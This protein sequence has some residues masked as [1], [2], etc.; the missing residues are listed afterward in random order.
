MSE[1][2]RVRA[3]EGQREGD[4]ESEAGSRLWALNCQHRARREARI[5]K[6]W[7]NDLSW[8]WT[9]NQLSHP[10]VPTFKGFKVKKAP[11]LGRQSVKVSHLLEFGCLAIGTG[12]FGLKPRRQNHMEKSWHLISLKCLRCGLV[13]WMTFQLAA[14]A[15]RRIYRGAWAAQSVKHPTLAQVMNSWFVGW[16]PM[17]GSANSSECGACFGFCFS[18][19]LSV[20]L[21]LMLCLSASLSQKQT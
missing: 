1:R 16:S 13:D 4:T 9:R 7:D 2:D 12:Q 3:G 17:W 5:H 20:P 11:D 8:G 15:S 21:L 6:P 10:G 18:L 14:Q 19:S